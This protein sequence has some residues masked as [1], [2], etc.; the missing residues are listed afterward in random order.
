MKKKKYIIFYMPQKKIVFH[1][2][3]NEKNPIQ[4]VENF[5]LYGTHLNEHMLLKTHID[6]ISNKI[7]RT[8]GVLKD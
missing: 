7:S 8:T 6:F 3:K 5:N 2:I 1:N 4:K